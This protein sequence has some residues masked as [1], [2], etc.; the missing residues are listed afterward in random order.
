MTE[1][2]NTPNQVGVLVR[3]KLPKR[4]DK[5]FVAGLVKSFRRHPVRS[6]PFNYRLAESWTSG[7]TPAWETAPHV[8][9]DYHLRHSALPHPGSERELAILISRL[10]SIPVDRHRPM[11]ELHFIEGLE[12]KNFA[13]YM[14]M[15][16]ALIDGVAGARMFSRWTSPDPKHDKHFVPLWAM[17]P[18]DRNNHTHHAQESHATSYMRNLLTQIARP[19]RSVAGVAGATF[20]TLRSSHSPQLDGLVAPYTCPETILNVPVRPQRRV[21]TIEFKT[22][23]LLKISKRLGGTLNDV[24]M[25]ICG[26][27]LRGYLI[28][29]G[30]LPDSPLVAQVPMSIRAAEDQAAG[31]AIGM[32]LASLATNEADPKSRFNAVKQSMSAA[33]TLLSSMSPTQIM[34][35]S[36]ALTL[37]F[38]VGQMTGLANRRRMPMFNVVISNVPGPREKRYLNGAEVVSIHPVSFVM[39][40]QALNITIFTYAKHIQL[41]LHRLPAVVAERA[42]ARAAH[43]GRARRAGRGG[44]RTAR[45]RSS[46]PGAFLTPIPSD[47]RF[48]IPRAAC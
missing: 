2:A 26:G 18:R 3:L 25:A 46:S 44:Q 27:A 7:I 43:L 1:S 8:D 10:H 14:K 24:V 45:L 48:P 15:H 17:P 34:A 32:V 4:A 42:K 21:S 22:S 13:I 31:N 12:G 40:G 30:A 36:A 5:G 9:L 39:Q 35:Y 29:Q 47:R 37:P 16:H 38:A 20:E 33:K 11:W 28:E 23:R 19:V 41:R 6:A